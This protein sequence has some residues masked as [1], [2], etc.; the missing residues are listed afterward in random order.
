MDRGINA[1]VSLRTLL[2][3]SG[4]TLYSPAS[5]ACNGGFGKISPSITG[6]QGR[7]FTQSGH[8]LVACQSSGT[9]S[10]LAKTAAGVER[11]HST[12]LAPSKQPTV[13]AALR[14]KA[15]FSVKFL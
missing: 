5:I 14:T 10:A 11:R 12:S 9:T 7:T 4:T 1:S 6:N 8:S 15:A 2:T 13:F 3:I